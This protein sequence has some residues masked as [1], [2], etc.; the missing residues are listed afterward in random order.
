MS[1]P[2]LI[3]R[4]IEGAQKTAEKALRLGLSPVVDPLFEIR[5][6]PWNAAPA[7]QYDAI[8]F[9]SANAIKMAGSELCKYTPL[10]ALAV[11]TATKQAAETIGFEIVQTGKSGV[12]SL[13]DMLPEAGFDRILRLSGTEYTAV[14]S[15]RLI[16]QVA[17]YESVCTGLGEHAQTA[18]ERSAV[19]L[20]HSTRAAELLVAEMA[21]LNISAQKNCVVAISPKVA[22]AAGNGWK[23]IDVAEHPTDEA[24]LTQAARLC[25]V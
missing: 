20:V 24:L 13:F 11:G 4:P 21:R 17:V 7:D 25:S 1:L 16:D 23:S 9:T 6:V 2:L 18:L 8:M 22:E 10:K 14:K 15:E 19:I 3:L 5:P 12:Q